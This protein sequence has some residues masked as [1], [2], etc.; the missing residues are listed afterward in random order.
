MHVWMCARRHHF[1]YGAS[2]H[3]L[4]VGNQS[5]TVILNDINM[6]LGLRWPRALAEVQFRVWV[7]N[8]GRAYQ[9]KHLH[10]LTAPFAMAGGGANEVSLPAW[11]LCVQ[12]HLATQHE[13]IK[14][15]F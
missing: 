10:L 8:F 7:H 14:V 6:K 9:L 13:S 11:S 15:Y 4:L 2:K 12:Q 3:V 1:G 5:E